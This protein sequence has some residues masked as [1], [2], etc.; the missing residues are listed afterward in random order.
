MSGVDKRHRRTRGPR[1]SVTPPVV[2]P[3]AGVDTGIPGSVDRPTRTIHA[4]RGPTR[5]VPHP[6][7]R[8]HQATTRRAAIAMTAS[9]PH[10]GGAGGDDLGDHVRLRLVVEDDTSRRHSCSGGED[11]RAERWQPRRSREASRTAWPRPA[12]VLATLT[13]AHQLFSFSRLLPARRTSG[14]TEQP[15]HQRRGGN[16]Q[17]DHRLQNQDHVDRHALGLHQC[18]HPP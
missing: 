6:A 11:R 18:N 8:R 13:C 3:E 5:A 16:Q 1:S 15:P 7:S 17:D 9:H 10:D 14:Q 4:D 12:S 2:E